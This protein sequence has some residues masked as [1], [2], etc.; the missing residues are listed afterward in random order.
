VPKS[1][2]V[3]KPKKR[4]EYLRNTHV[5]EIVCAACGNVVLAAY[6]G[7]LWVRAE[8]DAVHPAAEYDVIVTGRRTFTRRRHGFGLVWRDV[9]E[10]SAGLLPGETIHIEHHHRRSTR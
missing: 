10:I 3:A 2:G 1:T 4:F 9:A 5:E 8:K 7:G 6:D